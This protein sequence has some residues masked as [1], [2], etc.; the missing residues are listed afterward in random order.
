MRER[1][2]PD[3]WFQRHEDTIY[4][5]KDFDYLCEQNIS[6][7][8]QHF[9]SDAENQQRP[10]IIK[11]LNWLGFS[12]FQHRRL[13]KNQLRLVQ[14]NGIPE[15]VTYSGSP[16]RRQKVWSWWKPWTWFNALRDNS[17]TVAILNFNDLQERGHIGYGDRHLISVKQGTFAKVYINGVPCLLNEGT[18]VI[19]SSNFQFEG[20]AQQADTYIRHGDCH[21]LQIPAGKIVAVMIDNQPHLL[22]SGEHTFRSNNV[23]I[24]KNGDSLFYNCTDPVIQCGSMLR[25][26]PKAGHVAVYYEGNTIRTYPTHEGT[27]PGPLILNDR[28]VSYAD[29]LNTNLINR[30]YPREGEGHQYYEYYTKDSVKVGVKLF[31]AYQIVNPG[32][33]LSKLS[34]REIDEHIRHVT[35]VDMAAAGQETSLQN[36][37]STDITKIPSSRPEPS[38]DP[39]I[40]SAPPF[41][42]TWQ[43]LVKGKLSKD[44]EEYGIE[45]VRL[46]IE[47]IK[48]L[49]PAVE[50][51]LSEQAHRVAKA[52]SELASVDMEREVALKKASQSADVAR[53]QA[54]GEMQAAELHKQAT[55][56]KAEGTSQA[57]SLEA[58]VYQAHPELLQIEIARVMATALNGSDKILSTDAW[59]AMLTTGM[60][61]RTPAANV[62]TIPAPEPA[63]VALQ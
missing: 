13:E 53:I 51:K 27:D 36:I 18:H 11:Q 55:V 47:E 20:L 5:T 2:Y 61:G 28:N 31:V 35:H 17:H 58:K 9:N 41:I 19:K 48:I 1:Q 59:Q 24:H 32:L 38:A 39:H 26:M 14:R 34:P 22:E 45:L 15:L 12:L 37:Q 46:N 3:H 60:F 7:I 52:N 63:A 8:K 44:L 23:K 42:R 25:L 54:E 10:S 62:T 33:V 30:N 56:V 40:P 16:E 4:K 50:A 49:D 21:R 6:Q 57:K 29:T 43:D